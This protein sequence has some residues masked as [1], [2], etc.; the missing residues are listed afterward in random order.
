MVIVDSVLVDYRSDCTR[1]I[2]SM[3]SVADGPGGWLID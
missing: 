3:V 2:R 1:G